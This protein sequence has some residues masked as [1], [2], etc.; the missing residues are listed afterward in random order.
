MNPQEHF[1]AGRLETL[2]TRQ[3]ALVAK[4]TTQYEKV[5]RYEKSLSFANGGILSACV[6]TMVLVFAHLLGMVDLIGGCK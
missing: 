6:I 5:I 1:E 3:E 4:L 2:N